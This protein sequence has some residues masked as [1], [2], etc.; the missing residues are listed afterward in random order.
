MVMVVVLQAAAASVSFASP[1][2][3]AARMPGECWWPQL[4][5]VLATASGSPPP[6]GDFGAAVEFL[7]TNTGIGS[8][9][10]MTFVGYVV[11]QRRLRHSAAR[12]VDWF[13]D[14]YPYL[15]W[16]PQE[17]VFRVDEEAKAA[18]LPTHRDRG[19]QDGECYPKPVSI[20]GV[21]Q[22]QAT[23]HGTAP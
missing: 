23:R 14:H 4:E 10:D 1:E 19:P 2:R 3:Q 9:L 15:Y 7:E 17:R 8:G 6:P 18:G 12:W 11:K 20:G 16:D 21:S 5:L 13:I 22:Q